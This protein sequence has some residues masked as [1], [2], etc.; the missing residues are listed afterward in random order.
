MRADHNGDRGVF[1]A[2]WCDLERSLLPTAASAETVEVEP[3]VVD[4]E[5]VA[6]ADAAEDRTKDRLV[7]ILDALAAGAYQVMVVF[8]NAR[9]VGGHMP[10]PLEPRRHAR[11]DLRLERAVDCREAQTRMA[12][13]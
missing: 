10:R 5:V 11:F 1:R 8:G 3:L 2:P 7:D 4:L 12:A 6:I 13:V 9:D